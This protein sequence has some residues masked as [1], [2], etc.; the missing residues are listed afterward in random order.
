MYLDAFAIAFLIV[1]IIYVI[2]DLKSSVER[3]L[4]Q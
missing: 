1:F 4:K 3:D 2:L